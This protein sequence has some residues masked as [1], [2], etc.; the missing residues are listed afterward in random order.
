MTQ[1]N[2]FKENSIVTLEASWR[3]RAIGHAAK[4]ALTME[5]NMPSSTK[6]TS[7][8]RMV[9][10]STLALKHWRMHTCSP[11]NTRIPY[12]THSTTPKVIAHKSKKLYANTALFLCAGHMTPNTLRL[13]LEKIG[14]DCWWNN[15]ENA[16]LHLE[17]LYAHELGHTLGKII[18]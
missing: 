10:V 1:A 7:L 9:C 13:I 14:I 16:Q 2:T 5:L 15:H 17:T 6:L 18:R 11:Y 4:C 3:L 8:Y 12:N